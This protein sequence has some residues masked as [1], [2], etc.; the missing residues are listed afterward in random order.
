MKRIG[1]LAVLLWLAI[2]H[3]V[4][5]QGAEKIQQPGNF[6]LGLVIGEPGNWGWGVTG[7]YWLNPENAVQGAISVGN[8][9]VI[10]ADYLWNNYSIFH[11][12]QGI[13]FLYYGVGGYFGFSGPSF[14]VRVPVGISYLFSTAPVDLFVEVVP[15]LNLNN[16]VN[17][18][19][20]AGLGSR[21][22][23]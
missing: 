10:Q 17:V 21:Y 18:S 19:I 13:M 23:F 20:G 9:I 8:S 1:V 14:G 16:N 22:Y 6:G 15:T 4:W 2:I 3:P 5:A 7:K 11:P 12:Q